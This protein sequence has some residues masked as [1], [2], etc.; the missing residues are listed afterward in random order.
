MIRQNRYRSALRLALFGL[1]QQPHRPQ[2]W[3]WAGQACFGLN[4]IHAAANCLLHAIWIYPRYADA[5]A[6]LAAIKS[7]F[8]EP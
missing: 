1:Q 5:Q 3:Y 6:D 7:F 8:N 2:L 4:G